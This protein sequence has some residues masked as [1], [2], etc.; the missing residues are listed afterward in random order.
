MISVIGGKLTTA[1]NLARE[2]VAK[3]GIKTAPAT[4]AV[5][6]KDDVDPT[7]DHWAVEVANA[8]GISADAAHGI[9]EWYGRRA[10][11]VAS[12][13]RCSVQMRAP[14]CPHTSHIVAE[15]LH[16]FSDECAA[17]LA[18]VLLR[19]VPVALGAC[20]S[21]A[22]SREAATRIGAAVGWSEQRTAAELEVFER[23]RESFLRKASP[24]AVRAKAH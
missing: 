7:L 4:L 8:G 10:L 12:R 16:A 15:A 11:A 6:S 20:W 18:D 17:T 3:I 19:R 2:C 22:C 24:D 21:A 1:G 9:V 14:L 13:A 23:E 5:V